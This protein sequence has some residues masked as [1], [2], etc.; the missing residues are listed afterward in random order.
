MRWQRV[1]WE[2]EWLRRKHGRAI[3]EE[4]LR[5]VICVSAAIGMTNRTPGSI[6]ALCSER[7]SVILRMYLGPRI[8]IIHGGPLPEFDVV[9]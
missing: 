7:E 9:T 2:E 8:V 3:C 4:K 5:A 1:G 6:F